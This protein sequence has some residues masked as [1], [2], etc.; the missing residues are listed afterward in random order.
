MAAGALIQPC[1]ISTI[2]AQPSDQWGYVSPLNAICVISGIAGGRAS[3]RAREAREDEA[4]LH[5]GALMFGAMGPAA[6][7]SSEH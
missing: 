1:A 7:G 5:R 4:G 3:A 2:Q 6:A